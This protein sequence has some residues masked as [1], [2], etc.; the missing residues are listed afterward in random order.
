MACCVFLC[1]ESPTGKN[2]ALPGVGLP[3]RPA[4]VGALIGWESWDDGFSLWMLFSLQSGSRW[5]Q[6][7]YAL[8]LI[9]HKI[10]LRSSKISTLDRNMSSPFTIQICYGHSTLLGQVL[11]Q[12]LSLDTALWTGSFM[13]SA[14]EGILQHPWLLLSRSQ[15]P[16]TQK[17]L[18]RLSDVLRIRASPSK[19][20]VLS[21]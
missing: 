10:H 14:R 3:H 6:S 17:N 4:I 12:F 7:L 19:H 21:I 20:W 15:G 16:D 1:V 5:V 11:E 18:Q 13:C 2:T 8:V 9:P